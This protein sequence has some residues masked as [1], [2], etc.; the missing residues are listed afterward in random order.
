MLSIRCTRLDLLTLIS[1]LTLGSQ[2]LLV[3]GRR[4]LQRQPLS[5]VACCCCCSCC[6]NQCHAWKE[7]GKE[8]REEGR[9]DSMYG[10][11]RKKPPAI[12]IASCL[13]YSIIGFSDWKTRAL[14]RYTTLHYT[15]VDVVTYVP[16]HTSLY[17]SVS[18]PFLPSLQHAEPIV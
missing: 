15:P 16:L 18:F 5:E 17:R 3:K 1:R 2:E 7:E 13:H 12:A 8:G 6:R 14:L 4:R 10:S 9:A 11:T